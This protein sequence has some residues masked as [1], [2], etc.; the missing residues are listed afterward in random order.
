VAVLVA[1]ELKATV[2]TKSYFNND[3][4]TRRWPKVTVSLGIPD[5][6]YRVQSQSVADWLV[7]VP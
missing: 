3:L 4:L 6:P 2:M 1:E 5:V 7:V